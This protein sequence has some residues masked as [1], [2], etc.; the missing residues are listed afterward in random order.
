MM[1][2]RK[3]L[4]LAD[5]LKT[6][7]NA[8]ISEIEDTVPSITGLATTAAF[9]TVKNKIANYL[10]NLIYLI[11]Y[12]NSITRSHKTNLHRASIKHDT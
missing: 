3:Y 11:Y 9:I 7:Y 1:L 8:K 10:F 12:L 2:T 4:I 5:L 6:N